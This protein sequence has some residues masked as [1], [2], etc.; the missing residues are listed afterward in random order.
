MSIAPSRTVIVKS[1]SDVFSALPTGYASCDVLT[2][3]YRISLLTEPEDQ[4]Q[5][6]LN[7]FPD[8]SD[9]RSIVLKYGTSLSKSQNTHSAHS[10]ANAAA[11]QRIEADKSEAERQHSRLMKEILGMVGNIAKEQGTFDLEVADRL[12]KHMSNKRH[13]PSHGKKDSDDDQDD[14][15]DDDQGGNGGGAPTHNTDGH[16]QLGKRHQEDNSRKP[17][18]TVSGSHEDNTKESSSTR[19]GSEEDDGEGKF[20]KDGKDYEINAH[21]D[22]AQKQPEQPFVIDG[23]A[24][25]RP[26]SPGSPRRSRRG[27]QPRKELYSPTGQGHLPGAMDAGNECFQYWDNDDFNLLPVAFIQTFK[28]RRDQIKR[29]MKNIHDLKTIKLVDLENKISRL[30][31]MLRSPLGSVRYAEE[32][33][34]CPKNRVEG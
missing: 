30:S 9:E 28:R 4:Y 10:D 29:S 5:S 17:S 1:D 25:D 27:A 6:L 16:S 19:D 18:S 23:L 31:T 11:V 2:R 24:F 15:D 34:T 21:V 20:E 3:L 8:G 32:V 33:T 14:Q 12:H 22:L 7:S 13:R 26:G